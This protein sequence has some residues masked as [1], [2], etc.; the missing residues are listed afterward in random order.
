MTNPEGTPIWYELM[1]SDLAAAAPFYSAVLDWNIAA[2]TDP[3]ATGMDYRMIGCADGGMIGGAMA[4][5][6]EMAASGMKPCWLTYFGVEDVD[7]AV[8]G[9]ER[10]GGAVHMPATT[11]EGVGRM[12]MVADPQGA[13]FYL[14]RGATR[15]SSDVFSETAAGHGRWNE[16]STSDVVAALAFYDEV[17]SIKQ[18]GG[19]PMG[20]AGE[21]AF[22][23]AGGTTIGAISPMMAPGSQP[24]WLPYFGV[25][26]VNAA[27][28]AIEASGGAVMMG[29]QE[30]P[31]PQWIIIAH[32]PQGATFGLVGPKGE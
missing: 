8:T 30:V 3:L 21:Y 17:L 22:I 26:N 25:V 18:N 32:D 24:G 11:M 6:P 29:P 2:K 19:M 27:K 9:V 4:I 15:E 20:D 28:L 31:G 16:L 1:T 5:N 13:M 7:A 14:M 10:L 12:A 23:A